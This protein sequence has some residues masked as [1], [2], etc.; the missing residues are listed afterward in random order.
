M[1]L[2]LLSGGSGKRLWP[3]SNTTRSKQFLRVL[4][5]KDGQLESMVERVWNQLG[6]CSLQSSTII[7]TSQS[8]IEMI[9]NQIGL[10]VPLIIEPERRDTFAA[11][12]LAASYLYS[13]KKIKLDEVVG[14][15]PVDPYVEDDFFYRVLDLENVMLSTDA[16]VGLLGVKPTFPSEKYGYIVPGKLNEN[17]YLEVSHF[18]E[19]PSVEEAKQL[20]EFNALWNCG[21]FTFKLGYVISHL[22]SNGFPV[23]YEE[24]LKQYSNLPKRSFD[25]EVVEKAKSIITLPYEGYWKDLGTWN[26]LT[27][28]MGSTSLG[29]GII[30]KDSI[31]TH[32][33]NELDLPVIVLGINNALIATSPDGILVT[34]KSESPGIK[35]LLSDFEEPPKYKESLWGWYKILDCSKKEDGYETITKKIVVNLD[36]NLINEKQHILNEVWTIHKGNGEFLINDISYPVQTGDVFI[37]P[38]NNRYVL[39]AFS[40]M[41][42]VQVQIGY[43]IISK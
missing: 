17:T 33:V 29:N 13:I 20:I 26:T 4:E 32:V 16:E 1:E 23:R 5:N 6:N 3:L 2:I 11:I 34:G 12:A 25:Y 36:G 40:E 31:N 9:R 37:L 18:K 10:T 15:L 8:Q 24:L 22:E 21:V 35:D 42:A 7:A 14:I 41:E 28:E 27:E 38:S 39:T 30:T 19:K 43:N